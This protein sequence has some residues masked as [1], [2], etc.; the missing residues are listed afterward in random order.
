LPQ[1]G[2]QIAMPEKEKKNIFIVMRP[3]H[4][5]V[6]S[7]LISAIVFVAIRKSDLNTTMLS[8]ILWDVFALCY[9]VLS[10]IVFFTA[11]ANHISRIAQREDGSRMFVFIVVV[12]SSFIS[13]LTVLLLIISKD[14][15]VTSTATYLPAIIGGILLSWTLVH[16][17][18]CFHYAHL[19]YNIDD[20][21]T[22]KK[23]GLEFPKE[24]H[25]DYVDFAYFSFVIGMT[26][27]V[28]DIEISSRV[29]RRVALLHGLISF[30]LNTF[31]V[32]LT[33]NLIAGLKS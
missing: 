33:I 9:V 23:G 14:D 29:I 12:V 32:A 11:S 25:P 24:A 30:L 21:G 7:L 31:V 16:T 8:T 17:T 6:Y 2:K 13:M 1:T 26:F 4:R 20:T 22:S 18:F 3:L 27:Q 5:I 15:S 19:Y 28:S 10:W